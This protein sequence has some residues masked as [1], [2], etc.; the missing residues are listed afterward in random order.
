MSEAVLSRRFERDDG[1]VHLSLEQPQPWPKPEYD[2]DPN[3][4]PWRCF[5]SLRFPDDEVKRRY[6]VGIDSMQALL[7]ALEA[8]WGDLRSVGDDTP[9]QRPPVRWLGDDNLG[10]TLRDLAAII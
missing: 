1:F 5:Y 3:D 4:P 6:A 2:A 8:A 9:T 10:F 7:L